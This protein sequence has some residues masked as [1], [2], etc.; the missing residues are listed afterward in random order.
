MEIKKRHSVAV[1]VGNVWVGGDHPVVVQSMTNTADAA[2][3]ALQ[4]AQLAG[5]GSEIV[6]I[7]VNNKKAALCHLFGRLTPLNRCNDP[8]AQI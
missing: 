1:K 4:V 3:T 5:A 8:L 7:T 6:H 2:S